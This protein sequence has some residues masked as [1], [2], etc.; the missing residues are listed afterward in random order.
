M[1]ELILEIPLRMFAFFVSI[2]GCVFL[3]FFAGF[4]WDVDLA[5][6]W[7]ASWVLVGFVLQVVFAFIEGSGIEE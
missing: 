4:S 2:S 1:F 5:C 7:G 6:K 3:F